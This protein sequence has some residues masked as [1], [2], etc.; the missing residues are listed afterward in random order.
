MLSQTNE[1]QPLLAT[2]PEQPVDRSISGV[3]HSRICHIERHAMYGSQKYSLAWLFGW[4]TDDKTDQL[5]CLPQMG[6]CTILDAKFLVEKLWDARAQFLRAA[7]WAAMIFPKWSSF[8]HVI[9]H[10]LSE[11]YGGTGPTFREEIQV[12][13]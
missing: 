1:L 11:N 10:T 2:V 13:V 3:L 12:Y 5:S 9:W 4:Y 8:L 7:R 6:G